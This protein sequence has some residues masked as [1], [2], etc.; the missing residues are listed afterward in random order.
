MCYY[1]AH[2]RLGIQ[3]FFSYF[4]FQYDPIRKIAVGISG[5]INHNDWQPVKKSYWQ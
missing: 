1:A 4:Y 2:C 5:V 3:P